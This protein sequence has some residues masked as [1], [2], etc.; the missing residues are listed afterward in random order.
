MDAQDQKSR[1]AYY[2]FTKWPEKL[3]MVFR[4]ILTLSY[5][6]RSQIRYHRLSENFKMV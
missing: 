1:V 2:I 3:S 5:I 4:P 6:G